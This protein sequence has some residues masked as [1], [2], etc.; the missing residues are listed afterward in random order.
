MSAN[1]QQIEL[2][3]QYQVRQPRVTAVAISCAIIFTFILFFLGQTLL[4]SSAL[5]LLGM[6]IVL[7][8]YAFISHHRLAIPAWDTAIV[9]QVMGIVGVGLLFLGALV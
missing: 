4:V 9:G 1:Y 5:W 6:A 7:I 2:A 3:A 8:G